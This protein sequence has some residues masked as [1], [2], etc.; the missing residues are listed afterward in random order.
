MDH[1]TA[2]RIAQSGEGAIVSE[3][4]CVSDELRQAKAR[5]KRLNEII[6]EL[7]S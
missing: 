4:L 5:I 3:L 2:V 6:E 1:A 7:E